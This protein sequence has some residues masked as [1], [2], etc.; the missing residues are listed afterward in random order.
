MNEININEI[1]NLMPHSYPFLLVD[2]VT[3]YEL[4]K[5]ISG[6]KNV[7]VNEP[8]FTGHFPQRPI[9]PGVLM[10]EALAQLAGILILKGSGSFEDNVF[11]LAGIDKARFKKIVIPGDRLEM[12]ANFVKGKRGIFKV[13]CT[14]HV[15]DKLVC[16]ADIMI[17]KE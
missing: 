11:F 15:D 13:E 2:R 1:K 16:S 8:F 14:S 7:T 12:H 17:A 5:N 3:S 9:M 6:Y 4:D 10:V